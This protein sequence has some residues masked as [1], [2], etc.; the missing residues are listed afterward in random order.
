MVRS[1]AAALDALRATAAATLGEHRK[2]AAAAA[3]L[4]RDVAAHDRSLLDVSAA[5]AK[6]AGAAREMEA[7]VAKVEA[8]MAALRAAAEARETALREDAA[9]AERRA[10]AADAAAADA[11]AAAAAA[12]GDAEAHRSSE[13]RQ[14]RDAVRSPPLTPTRL[15]AAANSLAEVYARGF[16]GTVSHAPTQPVHRHCIALQDQAPAVAFCHCRK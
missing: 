15:F 11:R 10:A 9:A 13:V 5:A 2:L 16:E 7:T 4:E 6:R 8:E 12:A 1:K 3:Q 14:L